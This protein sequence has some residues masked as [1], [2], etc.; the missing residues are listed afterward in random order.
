[1][2]GEPCKSCGQKV[3]WAV[4]AKGKRVPLDPGAADPMAR[5]ALI[6]VD[7]QSE[8]LGVVVRR[9]LSF[10]AA[11][12]RMTERGLSEGVAQT[13]ALGQDARVSHFATCPQAPHWRRR[14]K[15]GTGRVQRINS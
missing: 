6:V 4:T 10:E 1:M 2:A 12:A 15:R 5:G 3:E 7:E 9:A 14:P 8:G 13:W 11:V